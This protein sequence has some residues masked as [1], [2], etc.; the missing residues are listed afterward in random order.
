V[1]GEFF[2]L[3]VD[4]LWEIIT[5]AL[6][7]AGTLDTLSALNVPGC[8]KASGGLTRSLWAEMVFPDIVEAQAY[9]LPMELASL[10]KVT[11]GLVLLVSQSLTQQALQRRTGAGWS[12]GARNERGLRKGRT[13]G[14]RGPT[15]PQNGLRGAQLLPEPA[16]W[17]DPFLL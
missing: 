10:L 2:G 15:G 8:P 16:L 9:C 4:T 6:V 17:G 5:S 3:P 13:E 12:S 11:F 1:L 14:W 7:P